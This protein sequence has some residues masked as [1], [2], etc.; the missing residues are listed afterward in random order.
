MKTV[1]EDFKEFMLKE[2]SVTVSTV[3]KSYSAPSYVE[4]NAGEEIDL[5]YSCPSDCNVTVVCIKNA[6]I[7]SYVLFTTYEDGDTERMAS[8]E[9]L[10]P[11]SDLDSLVLREKEFING[12]IEY[13]QA[14]DR[15]MKEDGDSHLIPEVRIVTVTNWENE[16]KTSTIFFFSKEEGLIGY[17]YF[18]H[19]AAEKREELRISSKEGLIPYV[20]G[21][22]TSEENEV[23]YRIVGSDGLGM[24]H[25]KLAGGISSKFE[26]PE[27]GFELVAK[28]KKE[29]YLFAFNSL[30]ELF[31][32][33]MGL[34]KSHFSEARILR[35]K[36]T[37]KIPGNGQCVFK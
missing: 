17:D 4:V 19:V 30:D 16:L 15:N 27:P 2:F 11:Y 7:K 20:S 14:K 34:M 6:D 37:H 9:S 28:T 26:I 13:F 33:A 22:M 32:S 25:S 35:I 29:G 10:D 36:Y 31:V 12:Q 3:S 24:Y 8:F 18:R 21:D 5:V 23:V 1:L